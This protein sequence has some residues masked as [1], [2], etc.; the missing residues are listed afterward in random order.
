M[1]A[2]DDDP[3]AGAWA[4]TV[5]TTYVVVGDVEVDVSIVPE[6]EL[7]R[8]RNFSGRFVDEVSLNRMDV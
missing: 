5:V 4:K 1:D 2:D 3:G 8:R 7:K 6:A